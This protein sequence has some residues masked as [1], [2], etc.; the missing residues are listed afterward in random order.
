LLSTSHN[1]PCPAQSGLAVVKALHARRVTHGGRSMTTSRNH[2]PRHLSDTA[3]ILLGRA[4]DSEDQ[5][6]LPIPKSVK[7]RGNALERVMRSLLRQGFVEEVPVG[8]ADEAWRSDH[9]GRYGLRITAAGL[10]AIGVPALVSGLEQPSEAPQ[11]KTPRPGSK[12]A[13]LITML[14][15][16]GGRTVDDLSQALGW[17]IHTIRAVIS[18]LQKSGHV[19]V[20]RQNEAG[21]SLY[22]IEAT[23]SDQD[24]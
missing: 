3:L 11:Q 9:D 7:A 21:V 24:A 22:R 4:A 8:L 12:L 20:R 5:M 19:V 14:M 1:L 2:S 17:Q 6:L 13:Q 10:R 15:Q 18:R 23:A 16:P